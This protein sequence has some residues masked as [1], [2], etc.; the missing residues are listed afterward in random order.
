MEEGP[1]IERLQS[2]AVQPLN[3]R[4]SGVRDG[5]M[6]EFVMMKSAY[7]VT[8]YFVKTALPRKKGGGVILFDKSNLL[9]IK[10]STKSHARIAIRLTLDKQAAFSEQRSTNIEALSGGTIQT[11]APHYI[12]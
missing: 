4:G 12:A 5:C 2:S 6:M 11:P 9:P 8:P 3:L 10:S 1:A 7:Q